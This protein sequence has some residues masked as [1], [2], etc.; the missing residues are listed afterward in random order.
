LKGFIEEKQY[1]IVEDV[2][3]PTIEEVRARATPG[4]LHAR[5]IKYRHPQYE[6]KFS[7]PTYVVSFRHERGF[8][9]YAEDTLAALDTALRD[10][11][12]LAANSP[13]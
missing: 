7:K 6:S 8:T 5:S 3:S 12:L 11:F 10:K 1:E 4:T 2:A 13:V 9:S